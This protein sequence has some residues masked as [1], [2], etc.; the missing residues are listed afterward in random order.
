MAII[1]VIVILI[2][3]TLSQPVESLTP[4]VKYVQPSNGSISCSVSEPCTFDQY[5][6]DSEQHFL[7]NTIFI[8]LPGEHQLNSSLTLDNIHNVSF[9][10]VLEERAVAVTLGPQVGLSFTNCT[11]IRIDSLNFILAGDFEYRLVF[12]NTT[13]VQLYNILFTVE[14]GNSCGC[15]AVVGEASQMNIINSSFISISGQFGAAILA[16]DS[17]NITF[18]G[19]NNFSNNSAE[20]GGAIHSINSILQFD[21]ITIFKDNTALSNNTVCSDDDSGNGGAVY[22]N[23]SQIIMRGCANFTSNKA[24]I[25]GGAVAVVNNSTV[26]ISGSFRSNDWSSPMGIIFSSNCI[27]QIGA[28]SLY[29]GSGGA[30]YTDNSEVKIGNTSFLNNFSPEHG[31]AMYFIQSNITLYNINAANNVAKNSFGGAI[32]IYSSAQAHIDGENIFVN[33]SAHYFGGAIEFCGTQSVNISGVNYFAGNSAQ[34]GGAFDLYNDAAVVISGNIVFKNNNATNGGAIY[35]HHSMLNCTG[36]MEYRHNIGELGGACF[37]TWYSIV[38]FYG[39]SNFTDNVARQN[40]GAISSDMNSEI[41][42]H[43][44]SVFQNNC[45]NSYGGAI[46]SSNSRIIYHNNSASTDSEFQFDSN[47]ADL[48]GAIAM[49]LSG[50]T[51]L[52]INPHVKII[53][54]ENQAQSF[55]GAIFVDI[56]TSSACLTETDDTRPE[57]FITLNT[58]NNILLNFTNNDA[59]KGGDVLYGGSLN[60]C[61]G[62]FLS[63]AECSI[64]MND[65]NHESAFDVFVKNTSSISP[66]YNSSIEFSSKPSSLCIFNESSD[67]YCGSP[68][69]MDVFPGGTFNVTMQA[70]DQYNNQMD[71]VEVKS[72]QSNTGDYRIN[73]NTIITNLM[74]PIFTFDV[75][76]YNEDLVMNESKLN[77]SLY[78]D[79]DGQ[80]RNSTHFDI[81]V[82]PC[83]LGFEFSS[84]IRKCNCAKLLQKFTEDCN[85]EQ[86]TIG[87]SSNNIWINLTTDYIIF[88]DG[89]CP[90]DYC[91]STK[92]YVPLD[93]SDMQ[94]SDGRTGRLCGECEDSSLALGSLTCKNCTDDHLLLVLPIGA[95]GILLIILLFLLRLTV[96]AGTINGLLFYANI[97]EAN[98]QIFFPTQATNSLKYFYTIF[99]GWLNLDF[100]IETCFY[101]GMD[102]VAYS[103]LQFLFPVYLWVLMFIIIL[104][105]RYSHRVAQNL[106]HNPVAVLATVLLISYGKMLKA[107]IV[108][109]SWAKL[110][111]IAQENSNISNDAEI[112]WLYN[113]NIPY[114]YHHHIV[115]VVFASLVLFLLFLP[116]SFL[117]LCGHLLQAKSHWR[118]LSWINKLK[119]F[120]DAYH[121]PYKKN[122]RHWIGLFLLARCSL[123]LTFAFDAAGV[124]DQNLNLLIVTS[125]TAILSI[126]KGRVYEK[127]YNDFL[128]SSFLL[129]LCIL[130]VA[131]FYVQ[132][133]K[134]F[135]DK[136]QKVIDNQ[137]IVSSVSVG[138]AFIFFI[139]IMVF[140]T[141]QRMRELDLSS[142]FQGVRRRYRLRLKKQSNKTADKEQ[143]M[144]MITKSS[145]CLRELLLDDETQT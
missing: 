52:I 14:D 34:N 41:N 35:I 1:G 120:M 24:T 43:G 98:H 47:C 16:L 123:V 54:I 89:A 66:E 59:K 127:W 140:H 33:N 84:D 99:I 83:P 94:C 103:W 27:C 30:I 115:L 74:Y 141:H 133:E 124:G 21:G 58:C 13:N 116:Y 11:S 67:N 26:D 19:T 45:A 138:I 112:V 37:I 32:R 92:V 15:S 97:V 107:I 39:D 137:S 80:C 125:V 2:L 81:T 134:S 93:D 104:S 85:I 53:F 6:N 102:I 51:K 130:S 117:L 73:P 63:I 111:T 113:G 87:R 122:D 56:Y 95:L 71:G 110:Q 60:E 91:K 50:T 109:L 12:S 48:G 142:F 118:V 132:S 17:S 29:C 44:D 25:Q 82:K 57:C 4:Q 72:T 31:G 136:P 78:V 9:Q 76:V 145:V 144:E 46:Y 65:Q 7:P 126:I 108:P 5:A 38:D 20:L 70:V 22:V 79:T 68:T 55:G 62:L 23:N 36:T 64:S 96:A 88:R 90:L 106:G 86:M 75:L 131:T 40:G 119:P 8:F 3:T 101:N 10:G 77:F 105:A 114:R 18:M 61:R 129:N 69:P 121:A 135:T 28:E 49:I 42:F 128:E 100:G 143:S 139:G